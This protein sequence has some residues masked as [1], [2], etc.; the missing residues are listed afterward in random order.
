MKGKT[1]NSSEK[2]HVEYGTDLP[3]FKHKEEIIEILKKEGKLIVWGQTGCG[4]TTQVPKYIYQE[5]LNNNKMIAVTQP[6]R[7]AA[8]TI[9][10]R[11]A[12]ELDTKLGNKVG[13]SIRFDK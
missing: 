8:V 1:L 4:K 12:K 6:R 7:V 10:Q 5:N 11:V 2:K 13:Y 3:I 9:S